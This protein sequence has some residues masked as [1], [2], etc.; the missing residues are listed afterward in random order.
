MN[1][2][3]THLKR[4]Y[5]KY[6]NSGWIL[7]FDFKKFFENV[8]HAALLKAIIPKIKDKRI[9]DLLKTLLSTFGN[10]GLGLGSQPC[11]ILALESANKLDHYIKEVLKIK[12]YQR[13]MDDGYLIS[14]SKKEL[15]RC[16]EK[17][18]ELCKKLGIKLNEKK[19]RIV[20][21]SHGF[22]FLKSR[23]YLLESG[24]I[25]KKI[26]K[27]SIVIERRKLKK[28]QKF[29]DEGLMRIEDAWNSFQSWRAYARTFNSYKTVFNLEQL[30]EELYGRKL[31]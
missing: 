27:K 26:R 11:Q 30:Y 3:E 14:N 23:I 29:I 10:K 12:N 9:L 7:Q 22:T 18:R 28:F 21:L 17:I 25:I 20:K 24:K 13:Y 31:S 19:I 15:T 1:R 5:R 6:R 2:L 8:S 16:L 4:H